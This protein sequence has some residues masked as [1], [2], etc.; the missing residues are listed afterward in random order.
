MRIERPVVPDCPH[1]AEAAAL[2][3]RAL[4]DLRMHNATVTRSVVQTIEDATGHK[5]RI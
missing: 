4:S 1:A 5:R 3:E 2:V